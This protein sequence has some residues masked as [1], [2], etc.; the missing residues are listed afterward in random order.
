MEIK[1]DAVLTCPKCGS[2]QKMIMPT[3]SCQ[4]F[5]KCGSC[6]ENLKPKKGD[7]CVFCSYSDTK[8][9]SKQQEELEVE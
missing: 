8:C 2:V 5:F 3:D 6:G 7:D 9:P 4:Y 1:L